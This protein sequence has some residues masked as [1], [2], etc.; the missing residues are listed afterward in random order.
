MLNDVRIQQTVDQL[1]RLTIAVVGDFFLD[2][3]LDLDARLTEKSVET[4]LDA[5]QVT[6]VR[7]SP[8]AGGTVA[9][10]LAALG[11]GRIVAL[12]VIGEDGEGF[13]LKRAL[14]ARGVDV[15]HVI[16]A[17]GRCTPTYTKPMLGD[18]C[19]PA[20]ELNRLDIKNRTPTPATLVGEMT[21]RLDQVV[22]DSD[23]VIVADQVSEPDCGVVTL[24]VRERL[25]ELAERHAKKP[26]VADSRERIGL[27]RKMITKPNQ[28]ECLGAVA[29]RSDA[30]DRAAVEA[31]AQELARRTGRPVYCT[32]GRDGI[33]F[34]TG[35]ASIRV[36]AFPVTGPIDVVGAGDSTTAGIVCGLC[37]GLDPIDAA[38]LGN[39]IASITIRQLG[40]TGTASPEQI[41]SRWRERSRD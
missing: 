27:F 17:A 29:A 8:G 35:Q 19:G 41:L 6:R 20:R 33:L 9:N 7:T 15:T 1:P 32:L 18:G 21:R 25:A 14:V 24:A 36:P 22:A 3:Y 34:T 40:T 23:A 37:T 11:V 13:E 30:T 4:G 10:N 2:K 28:S 12:T 26:I 39:L 5:Y 31:A 16:E 38:T